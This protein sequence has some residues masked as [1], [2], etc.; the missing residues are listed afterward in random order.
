MCASYIYARVCCA[1]CAC[2]RACCAC[3]NCCAC[4]FAVCNVCVC[5][6]VFVVR[7]VFASKSMKCKQTCS[8]QHH[9]SPNGQ[10]TTIPGFK[11]S[12]NMTIQPQKLGDNYVQHGTPPLCTVPPAE[13]CLADGGPALYTTCWV[14]TGKETVA[15]FVCKTVTTTD[16]HRPN[17]DN[18]R[19][20]HRQD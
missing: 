19:H 12:M 6:C 17:T 4:A 10:Q 3:S 8:C 9:K 20:R 13:P 11:Q 18:H 7:V 1:C 2:L 16:K 15:Q 5:V 14:V